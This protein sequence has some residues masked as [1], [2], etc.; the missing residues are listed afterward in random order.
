MLNEANEQELQWILL[1]AGIT[2]PASDLPQL[3][4]L[5]HGT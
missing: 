1:R 3:R 5:H 2:V 4:E